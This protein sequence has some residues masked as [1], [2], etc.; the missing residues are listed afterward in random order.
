MVA[1]AR[2]CRVAPDVTAVE[3]T[4]DYTV[5]VD[6]APGVRVGSVVRVPLH[7]RRVRGWVVADDVVPAVTGNLLP[8]VA[9]VS[10]GPP[11]DVVELASW[12]AHRWCGPVVAVLRSASPPNVV[13]P[14]VHVPAARTAAPEHGTAPR[15]VMRVPPLHD[16]RAVVESLL[17]PDASTIV[18]VADAHRARALAASLSRTG[19]P[20]ALMHS[21]E[22]DAARTDAWWRAAQGRCVVVGGRVAAFAPVPDLGA[23]VV[24]D[25]ADE[26]LQEE[27]V[28]TWHARD[29]LAER[30]RRAGAPFTVVS[31]AP[32]VEALAATAT[33]DAPPPDVEI[34]G[35]PRTLVVDRREEPPG[36][37]LLTGPLARSLR[38]ARG[39]AV[40]VLN[41]R[42]RFR[43]LACD[44]CR[45]LLRW[46]R[47]ADRPAICPGCGSTRLRVL[48]A[49]VTRIREELAALL[50]ERRIL[51]VDADAGELADDVDVV[52]GTEAALHRHEVRRRRPALV[53]YLDLDQE[54]LAPRYRASVQA[55]WLVARGAQLLAARPRDETMLLVQTRMPGH[56]VVEAVAHGRPQAVTDAETGRRGALRYPP[57]G[58][59]A[60]LSGDEHAL[61]G[62]VTALGGFDVDVFGPSDGRALVRADDPD[63]LAV[64]LSGAAPVG[65]ARG[66]LRVAV[67][68]PR[69]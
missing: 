9:V 46:D 20:V 29:V 19:R 3:R 47:A 63:V 4:F 52:V 60:E 31:P 64:A 10:E 23:V 26:A 13:R 28:P 30:A 11:P 6:L 61:E 45:E 22:P 7:G 35:W 1:G 25:D 17:A 65:R 33:V 53:A 69:V 43:L 38:E 34:T 58:A 40:C 62:T 24:V 12:V 59:L 27:R 41:R 50:P 48:R 54:L 66:R 67:D 5:P 51:D 21:D 18:C 39:L 16:R 15:R 49:G 44:A 32:T 2:V 57:F 8:L 55:L 14:A 37:R 68:P 36:A 56:E 42:G